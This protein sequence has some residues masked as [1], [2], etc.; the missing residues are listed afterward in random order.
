MVVALLASPRHMSR[1]LRL[2]PSGPDRV[3][4]LSPLWRLAATAGDYNQPVRLRLPVISALA[5]KIIF[6]ILIARIS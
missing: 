6:F 4:N 2:L 1:L 5:K 3:H